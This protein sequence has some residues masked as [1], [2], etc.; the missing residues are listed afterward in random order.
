[1][2]IAFTPQEEAF[3]AEVHGYLQA[4]VPDWYRGVFVHPEDECNRAWDFSTD[5][6]RKLAAKGWLTR[7]WP[8]EFGG[9]SASYV[10]QLIFNEEMEYHFE[11]RGAYELGAGLVSW[12]I[13]NHGSD[14]QKRRF[15]PDIAS[16][17]AVWSQGFTEPDAGSDLASLKTR[18]ELQGDHFLVNGQKIYTS[19][20]EHADWY[21][22]AVRTDPTLPKH[23][24]ISFLLIDMHSP[25]IRIRPIPA[26][27]GM[28]FNEVFLEDVVVPR[29]NLVGEL[30]GGWRTMMSALEHE[31]SYDPGYMRSLRR[32]HDL[33]R[34]AQN[35][36]VGDHLLIDETPVKL[37]LADMAV[38]IQ[39][40]RLLCYKVWWLRQQGLPVTYEASALHVF[41]V[42][43]G[44]AFDAIAAV[45][46]RSAAIDPGD[47][48]APLAGDIASMWRWG[49]CRVGAGTP[50]VNKQVIAR[51]GLGLPR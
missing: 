34:Y 40:S 32:L 6:A 14:D 9:Q 26:V 21:F 37:A 11:P 1:M 10:E 50:E 25:G 23:R 2:R 17:R 5:F 41:N 45:L 24:G 48:L 22:V 44:K 46:G 8:R 47:H 3:R 31:R 27:F 30:N 29:E 15:L 38:T 51:R 33:T 4:E 28:H 19:Y 35:K 12:I 7:S 42:E 39:A 13:I 36:K 16:A 18:A 43:R 49:R 20:A